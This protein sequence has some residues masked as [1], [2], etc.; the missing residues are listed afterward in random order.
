MRPEDENDGA[1][2]EKAKWA[3]EFTK[4]IDAYDFPRILELADIGYEFKTIAEKLVRIENAVSTGGKAT[5]A[6]QG[7]GMD[8]FSALGN[9]RDIAQKAR[10]FLTHK[11][12]LE[13]VE[14]E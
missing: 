12:L 13:A 1:L 5:F 4:T 2:L 11:G 6:G 3:W 8:G 9:F 7:Q 10:V 14:S